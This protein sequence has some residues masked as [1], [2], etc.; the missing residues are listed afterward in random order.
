MERPE[1]PDQMLVRLRLD[2]DGTIAAV[3]DAFDR[4]ARDNHSPQISARSVVGRRLDDFITGD[5][6]RMFVSVL[7]KGAQVLGRES[8]R[9]YRCDSPDTK[10]LMEM[11]IAPLAEGGVEMLHRVVWSESLPRRMAFTAVGKVVAMARRCSMCNRLQLDGQWWEPDQAPLS[12]RGE[13]RVFY[14]ICEDCQAEP[15]GRL[16]VQARLKR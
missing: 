10:R 3:N 15:A 13:I 4:F 7:I 2:P 14:G 1:A 5:E 16:A 11:R 6:T 8:T 12:E 9:L